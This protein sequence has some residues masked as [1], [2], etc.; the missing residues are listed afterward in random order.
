[1]HIF[2]TNGRLEGGVNP[3]KSKRNSSKPLLKVSG[4]FPSTDSSTDT[5]KEGFSFLKQWDKMQNLSGMLSKR[6]NQMD[7]LLKA[8]HLL[9]SATKDKNMLKEI[10]SSL[11]KLNQGQTQK[12]A[13]PETVKSES[14]PTLS[15]DTL[16]DLLNSP[17]LTN[18]TREVMKKKKGK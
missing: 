15:G 6:T 2:E 7:D 18:L 4:N 10:I 11:A 14:A 17:A 3:V 13:A 8:L 1:M 16:Y 12:K 5:E 9:S